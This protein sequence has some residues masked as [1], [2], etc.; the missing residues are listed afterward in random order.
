MVE[1][2]APFCCACCRRR[3]CVS[4]S[5]IGHFDH[6]GRPIALCG[7][8][9]TLVVLVTFL[10]LFGWYNFNPGSFLNILKSYGEGGGGS[11]YGQWS[12]VGRTAVTMLFGKHL[13]SGHWNVT[14]VCNGLLGGFAVITSGCSMVE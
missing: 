6:T 2:D 1:S 4:G 7:D 5:C 9:T 3:D 14:N 10:F 11:N 13:M 12:S 8:S